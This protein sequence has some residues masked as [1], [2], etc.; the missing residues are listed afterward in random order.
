MATA[1]SIEFA[2]RHVSKGIARLSEDVI[3]RA[4]GSWVTLRGRG[5]VLD[6]TCGIGV[7]NLGTLLWGFCSAV[8]C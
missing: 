1:P 8:R 3:E 6:F 4:E 2:Q 7:T 5:T